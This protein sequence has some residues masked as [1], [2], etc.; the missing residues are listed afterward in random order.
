MDSIRYLIQIK[1]LKDTAF[2][3]SGVADLMQLVNETNS[4]RKACERMHMS[5]SKGWK[6]IKFAEL[7]LGFPLLESKAGGAYGGGSEITD[8]GKDFLMCYLQ[9]KNE[10]YISGNI[11]F[12]K[13]FKYY[14]EGEKL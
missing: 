9:F 8:K 2:F 7:K 1:L 3:G 14:L 4:L 5:Y 10:L 12:K 13:H 11:L 6:I